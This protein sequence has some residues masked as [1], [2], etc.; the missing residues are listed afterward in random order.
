MGF[1]WPH[2][3]LKGYTGLLLFWHSILCFTLLDFAWQGFPL[4][5]KRFFNPATK[6]ALE[7]SIDAEPHQTVQFF[8][9]DQP[10]PWKTQPDLPQ[11]PIYKRIAAAGHLKSLTL[12]ETQNYIESGLRARN[13]KNCPA[14]DS[15]A[16]QIIH[17]FSKGVPNRISM[18]CNHL[19]LQCF[20]EQRPKITA[21][22]V[23][24]VVDELSGKQLV[25]QE[26][27]SEK[28]AAPPPRE[29]HSSSEPV[30][31]DLALN[32]CLPVELNKSEHPLPS[33]T[34]VSSP[35][36]AQFKSSSVRTKKNDGRRGN[37]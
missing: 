14:F 25:V 33:D 1:Q 28:P 31:V 10:E 20:V 7:Q 4:I 37:W 32:E 3:P 16:F 30:G 34:P 36:K 26:T 8:M 6:P 12:Q 22:N 18:I 29:T 35:Q 11:E 2:P 27:Q 23:R 24:A 9:I 13:W 21:A 19:L 17:Q 5:S 15:E